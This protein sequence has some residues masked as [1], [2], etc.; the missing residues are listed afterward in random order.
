MFTIRGENV[1]P[2]AIDEVLTALPDYGGEHRILVSREETMDKLAVRVEHR[3]GLDDVRRVRGPRRRRRCAPRS[4]SR[5][6]SCR[7]RP[8]TF[9]RTEFKAR[10]VID[11]RALFHETVDA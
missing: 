6:R 2:R 4:A 11:E 10:R 5:P 8:N 1:Y 3:A 7:C 9:E